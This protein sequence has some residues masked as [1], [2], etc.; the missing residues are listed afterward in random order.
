M[1]HGACNMPQHTAVTS[2]GC[3]NVC[4]YIVTCRHWWYKTGCIGLQ[5]GTNLWCELGGCGETVDG[6]RVAQVVCQILDGALASDNGL[7]KES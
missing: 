5:V 1:I 3:L 2:M 4:V 6:E 7:D